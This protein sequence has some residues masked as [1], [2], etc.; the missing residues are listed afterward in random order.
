M[1]TFVYCLNNQTVK[2]VVHPE[3]KILPSFTHPNVI[4]YP[5][6]LAEL[7]ESYFEFFSTI[8]QSSAVLDPIDF[9]YMD[10][11]F[12]Y[13]MEDNSNASLERHEGEEMS[14]IFGVNF[15]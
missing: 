3:I 10:K 13:S 2:G 1:D 8:C 7:K 4:I 15:G 5:L 9:H 14:S 11:H 6:S 12:L